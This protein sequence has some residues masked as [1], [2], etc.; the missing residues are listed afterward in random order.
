MKYGEIKG[1]GEFPKVTSVFDK[2]TQKNQA[3]QFLWHIH[4][5]NCLKLKIHCSRASS[6]ADKATSI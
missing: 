3:P 6:Y 2:K 1:V 4:R 5:F